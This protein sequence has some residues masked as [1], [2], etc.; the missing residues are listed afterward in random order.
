MRCEV[1][2]EGGSHRRNKSCHEHTE[3]II[4]AIESTIVAIPRI[5]I[6]L[7]YTKHDLG[8]INKKRTI[9]VKK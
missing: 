7:V 6:N 4:V 8:K 9:K 5:K 2:T 3:S 1:H